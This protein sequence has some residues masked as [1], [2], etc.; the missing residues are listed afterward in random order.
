MK[1]TLEIA[2][3]NQKISAPLTDEEFAAVQELLME[4]LN[5]TREQITPGA[6]IETDLGADSLDKVEILMKAEERFNVTIADDQAEPV[7]TVEDLCEVLARLL[8]R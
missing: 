2:S 5:I 7:R 3:P 4:Q 1:T 8:G 6:D